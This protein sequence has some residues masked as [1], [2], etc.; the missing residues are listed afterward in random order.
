VVFRTLDVGGDK[1]LP[2]LRKSAGRKPGHGLARHAHGAGSPG[3]VRVQ[4]R[5]LLAAAAGRKLSIMFPLI[6]TLDEFRASRDLFARKA[7]LAKI[8]P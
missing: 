6:T 1:V 7:A 8:W 3:L 4:I 2:Y 5:A